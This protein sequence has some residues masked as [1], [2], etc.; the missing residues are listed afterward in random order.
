MALFAPAQQYGVNKYIFHAPR[1]QSDD[2]PAGEEFTRF[3][4]AGIAKKSKP[5][6]RKK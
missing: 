5:S 6:S 4:L 3:L 2:E 1:I